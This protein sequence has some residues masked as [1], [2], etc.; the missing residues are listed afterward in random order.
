MTELERI[1]TF[2]ETTLSYHRYLL[3][4]SVLYLVEQTIKFLKTIKQ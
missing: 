3:E 1:I 2:W 4:P